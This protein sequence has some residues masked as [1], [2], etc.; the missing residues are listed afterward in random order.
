VFNDLARHG[1]SRILPDAPVPPEVAPPFLD[2]NGDGIV[3]EVDGGLVLAD[4]NQSGARQL[5]APRLDLPQPTPDVTESPAVDFRLETTD[6][7]GVAADHFALGETFYLNVYVTDLRALGT[8]VFSAYVDVAYSATGLATAGDFEFGTQFPLVHAGNRQTA[9]VLDEVGGVH[10]S[11][12]GD[13]DEHL[14]FRVP[15]IATSAGTYTIQSDPAD[16][17]P[18]SE[19]TLFGA[20]GAIPINKISF[21]ATTVTVIS[22]DSDG[23]GVQDLEE[24]AAPNQGDGNNDGTPDRQQGHVASLRSVVSQQ[25]VTIVAPAALSLQNVRAVP[26]PA[27]ATPPANV[28]FPHGFFEFEL[29]G[30]QAG[31][32]ATLNWLLESG[33]IANAYYR[34]GATSSNPTPHLAAHLFDGVSGGLVRAS[35]IDLHAVDGVRGD[36]DRTTNGVFVHRG[37]PALSTRP[38]QNPVLAPDVTNESGVTALDALTVINEINANGTRQLPMLPEGDQTIPPF[39]DVNGDGLI[40][41]ADVLDVVNYLNDQAAQAAGGEGESV[42]AVWLT[43]AAGGDGGSA[44]AASSPDFG[45]RP[46]EATTLGARDAEPIRPAVDCVFT[47]YGGSR[48]SW[49]MRLQHRAEANREGTG[50]ELLGAEPDWFVEDIAEQLAVIRGS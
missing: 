39:L 22:M 14:L 5:P 28:T 1:G 24:D 13:T 34:F 6:S 17:L 21:G 9:G 50:D 32:S 31:G 45:R 2:V 29:T 27:G 48:S 30:V 38:W 33:A 49:Q 20:D 35:Q 25:F 23:D 26:T 11:S 37:S 7:M 3:S 18:A 46:F 47:G 10:S 42:A 40:S 19:V 43:A 41:A 16:N 12:L 44:A 15:M 36:N 4:L 8:G